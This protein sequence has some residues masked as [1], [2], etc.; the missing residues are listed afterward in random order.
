MVAPSNPIF[1]IEA[2][3]PFLQ[4]YQ[5]I[6]SALLPDLDLFHLLE[7]LLPLC[8][9]RGN[10]SRADAR[11]D[12]GLLYPKSISTL[13]DFSETH[14]GFKKAEMERMARMLSRPFN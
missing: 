3:L 11:K 13:Q 5:L 4:A 8:G 10:I 1:G 7:L 6:L 9:L 14:S 2:P 12:A